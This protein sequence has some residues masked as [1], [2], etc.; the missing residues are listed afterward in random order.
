MRRKN[1]ETGRICFSDDFVFTKRMKKPIENWHDETRWQIRFTSDDHEI[2][3]V[4]LRVSRDEKRP[5]AFHFIDGPFQSSPIQVVH[6]IGDNEFIVGSGQGGN[7]A[8]IYLLALNPDGTIEVRADSVVNACWWLVKDRVFVIEGGTR[9]RYYSIP[10]QADL[11]QYITKKIGG[12]PIRCELVNAEEDYHSVHLKVKSPL[13]ATFTVDTLEPVSDI[14]RDVSSKKDHKINDFSEFARLVKEYFGLKYSQ[15]P[16]LIGNDWSIGNDWNQAVQNVMTDL[17]PMLLAQG[18]L[19]ETK[20]RFDPWPIAKGVFRYDESRYSI[21]RP[22]EGLVVTDLIHDATVAIDSFDGSSLDGFCAGVVQIA[23]EGDKGIFLAVVRSKISQIISNYGEELEVYRFE[24]NY[25]PSHK[26]IS[27]SVATHL[28]LENA[29]CLWLGKYLCTS[30]GLYSIESDS[31]INNYNH[32]R[33]NSYG[34]QKLALNL[35]GRIT[36]AVLVAFG[37]WEKAVYA[38]VRLDNLEIAGNIA[39][40]QGSKTFVPVHSVTMCEHIV[41]GNRYRETGKIG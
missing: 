12:Q 17:K 25:I 37:D 40:D 16:A 7:V 29:D 21:D 31:I 28:H 22:I 38:I 14:A 13:E 32:I 35:K 36:P 1:I 20:Y 24:I 8:K 23:S 10:L 11:E 41:A 18:G 34:Q 27:Y 33:Q 5:N 9:F 30:E 39:Y 19:T 2:V 15:A 26:T 6:Q 4:D 3:F